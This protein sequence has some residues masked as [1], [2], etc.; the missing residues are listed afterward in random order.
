MPRVLSIPLHPSVGNAPGSV[1]AFSRRRNPAV[2][3]DEN[4]YWHQSLQGINAQCTWSSHCAWLLPACV[5]VQAT[6][7]LQDEIF[8]LRLSLLGCFSA[9]PQGNTETQSETKSEPP[10]ANYVHL[11]EPFPWVCSAQRW[12]R[13]QMERSWNRR[14]RGCVC[15]CVW[16]RERE[17]ESVSGI[18]TRC[19]PE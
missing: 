7:F 19:S 8:S 6:G 11:N 12:E 17:R 14:W 16:E 18:H 9:A 13:V 3:R 1:W 5:S 4:M 15:V 2:R 10:R